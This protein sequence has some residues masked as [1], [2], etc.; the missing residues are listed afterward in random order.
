[1]VATE[2]TALIDISTLLAIIFGILALLLL[3]ALIGVLLRCL[4]S[5]CLE[6]KFL[7]LKH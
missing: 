2:K 1:V 5:K 3:L 7:I 6:K 4:I